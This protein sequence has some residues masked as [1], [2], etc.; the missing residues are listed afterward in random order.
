MKKFLLT[1]LFALI[2]TLTFSQQQPVVAVFPFVDRYDVLTR[3]E[4]DMFYKMFINE[5]SNTSRVRLV[6][7]S[8]IDRFLRD[9]HVYEEDWTY[10][11]TNT[12]M[13]LL[14]EIG[15]IGPRIMITISLINDITTLQEMSRVSLSVANKNELFNKIPELVQNMQNEIANATVQ[16]IPEGLQ[17]EIVD[18]RTVTITGYSGNTTI[19]NIPSRINGLSVTSIGN[20]VFSEY[21]NL[22][23]VTIPSSVTSIGNLAFSYCS[24]LTS[25]TVDNRNPAYA[26][27]DGVLFE[28]SIRTIIKYPIGKTAR[29]YTIPSSVTSIGD[30]A[31]SGCSSLTSVTIPS[32]VTS[33]G[34]SAFYWCDSLTSVTIPSSVTSIGEYAFQMC[35]SLTSLTLSRRTRVEEFAFPETTQ[36]IY[37]D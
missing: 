15:Q 23:S 14:G 36:I 37:R 17:Y 28:K 2:A 12:D 31:F 25:I 5:L 18:G 16:Q 35:R 19:L 6:D 32:S 33:I 8:L 34:Y 20:E 21:V 1:A 13:I 27:I 10:L 7:R 24:N 22:T 9:I 4:M 3:N 30:G 26:S 11:T 29:N